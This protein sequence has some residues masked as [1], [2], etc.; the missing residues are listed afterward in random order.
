MVIA[1]EEKNWYIVPQDNGYS[2]CN[3]R[4]EIG[5]SHGFCQRLLKLNFFELVENVNVNET[6]RI[7]SNGI[8]ISSL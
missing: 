8:S 6:K 2:H 3:S 4:I 7:V 5:V 1:V